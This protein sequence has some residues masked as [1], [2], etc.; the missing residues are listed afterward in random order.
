MCPLSSH[1]RPLCIK[2]CFSW[3]DFSSQ[4]QTMF[5]HTSCRLCHPPHPPH[6]PHPPL[7]SV[8]QDLWQSAPRANLCVSGYRWGGDWRSLPTCSPCKVVNFWQTWRGEEKAGTETTKRGAGKWTNVR[9]SR[10]LL[11]P[12]PWKMLPL[13]GVSWR[14][15]VR[16]ADKN[17]SL[18]IMLT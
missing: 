15:G 4:P 9:A 10:G 18:T 13:R 1:P 2:S 5:P 11:R 14:R 16:H 12:Q 6:T 17:N 8:K 7:Q 3:K